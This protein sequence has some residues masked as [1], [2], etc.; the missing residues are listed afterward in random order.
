MTSPPSSQNDRGSRPLSAAEGRRHLQPGSV[1][2]ACTANECEGTVGLGSQATRRPNSAVTSLPSNKTANLAGT[3]DRSRSSSARLVRPVSHRLEGAAESH[4]AASA[5][6]SAAAIVAIAAPQISDAGLQRPPLGAIGGWVDTDAASDTS[7]PFRGTERPAST[8][9][10]E[11]SERV[12]PRGRVDPAPP[13]SLAAHLVDKFLVAAETTQPHVPQ[14][15][16]SSRDI[17]S[18]PISERISVHSLSSRPTSAR[19]LFG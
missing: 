12:T 1:R 15:P 18:R 17:A 9:G 4:A 5:A 8:P 16:T 10:A 19:R 13:G 14:T 6:A 11:R 3:P 7:T 2:C